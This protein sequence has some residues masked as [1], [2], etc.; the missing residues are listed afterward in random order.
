MEDSRPRESEKPD[1]VLAVEPAV[2]TD[3]AADRPITSAEIDA[4][5]RLLGEDLVRLLEWDGHH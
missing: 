5:R 3:L 4:I 2:W 1:E